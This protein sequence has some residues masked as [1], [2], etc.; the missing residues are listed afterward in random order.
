VKPG[1]GPVCGVEQA[2]LMSSSRSHG[3]MKMTMKEQ[4]IA[5]LVKR[6]ET[7]VKETFKYVVFSRQEGGHYYVGRAG[8]LRCGANIASS[9]PCSDKFKIHLIQSITA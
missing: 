9:I 8:A 2:A 3:D 6:G 5:A 7:Q 4:F 1:Y